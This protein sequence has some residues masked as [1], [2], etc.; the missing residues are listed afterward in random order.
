MALP[1]LPDPYAGLQLGVQDA[2][3][4]YQ[5]VFTPLGQS[6]FGSFAVIMIALYGIE[7]AL[8]ASDRR[9]GLSIAGFVRLVLFLSIGYALVTFYD[10]PMPGIGYTLPQLIVRQVSWMVGLLHTTAITDIHRAIDECWYRA[11]KPSLFNLV[12]G[13]MYVVFGA[14]CGLMKLALFFVIAFGDVATAVLIVLGPLFI[15]FLI[16][17]YLD[18]LFWAWFRSLLIYAFYQV[19]AEVYVNVWAS[20]LLHVLDPFRGGLDV[21]DL[22]TVFAYMVMVALSFVFG[23]LLVPSIVRSLF[24]GS[25]GESIAAGA[26]SAVAASV[27][28]RRSA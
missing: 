21:R 23:M 11:E 9:G 28:L 20:F 18:F 12:A 3:V 1:D 16:V 13:F 2:L 6:L 22:I 5:G 17:P 19:V 4:H 7:T 25:G 8:G 15:P 24:T 14:L 10:V 27:G 26:L